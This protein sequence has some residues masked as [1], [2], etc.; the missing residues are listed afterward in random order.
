MTVGR[1]RDGKGAAPGRP[2]ILV[3]RGRRRSAMMR[4]C[5]GPTTI[6]FAAFPCFAGC[7]SPQRLRIAEVAHVTSHERGDLIFAEGDPCDAFIAIVSGR[8]KVFK[9]TPAGKEI[10]LEIFG[11][12]DPLGAVAVYERVPFMASAMALERHAVPPDRADGVLPA[13]RARS[14]ARAR[15]AVGPD[16][17]AGRADAPAGRAHR[18]A[19]RRR[20]SRDCS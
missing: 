19:G 4:R 5:R 20:A 16:A 1:E 17:S 11:A 12:G 9:S 15:P 18:R 6:S 3:P 14:G 8:V 7:Q 13:A 2:V 10:I